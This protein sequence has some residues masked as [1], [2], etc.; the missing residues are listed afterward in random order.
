MHRSRLCRWP[1]HGHH[2][3][4]GHLKQVKGY[5][6]YGVIADNAKKTTPEQGVQD[7]I[8]LQVAGTPDQC[9]EQ[10]HVMQEK[11]GFDHLISVFS[12]GGMPPEETERNMKLFA[13]EV[14]PKL[15]SQGAPVTIGGE[16]VQA[17]AK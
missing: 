14:M 16:A 9:L 4:D 5:E 7:F 13:A 10:I 2:F 17:T 11:V 6:H 12:Y 1:N 8:G 3:N 15:Q